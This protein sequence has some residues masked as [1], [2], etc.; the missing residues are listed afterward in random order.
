MENKIKNIIIADSHKVFRDALKMVL[1]KIGNIN[2]IAE[3][4]CGKELIDVIKQNPVDIILLDIEMPGLDGIEASRIILKLFPK[5]KIIALTMFN[6]PDYLIKIITAGVNCFLPKNADKKEIERAINSV[7]TGKLFFPI[8][9]NKIINNEKFNYMKTTKIL[10]VDDDEDVIT[11]MKT[12]LTKKGFEVVTAYNKEE[13]LKK[14]KEELPDL[15]ILDVMMTT[16]F[17][18]FEMA[19]EI[20]DDPELR[21]IPILMQTSI[22]ILHTSNSYVQDMAREFRKTPG[23]KDLHVLL[24]KDI[25]SGNAGI[26]YLSE[27]G[28]TIWFPVDGFLSK[29]FDVNKMLPEVERVIEKRIMKDLK[30]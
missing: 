9:F 26:D 5:T 22:D 18:G 8:H 6:D 30:S 2:V 1:K 24:V 7:I 29:P 28:E 16:Q 12:I 14:I 10:I 3:V 20:T 15:A 27:K 19:K 17:E 21:K 11:V 23:Y 4:S 13:G 25:V